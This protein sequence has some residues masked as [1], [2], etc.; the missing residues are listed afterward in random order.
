MLKGFCSERGGLSVQ[1]YPQYRLLDRSLFMKFSTCLLALALVLAAALA[2]GCS[3]PATPPATH[4]RAAYA[5]IATIRRA[6]KRAPA[7]RAKTSCFTTTGLVTT[8]I[9]ADQTRDPGPGACRDPQDGQ[10]SA[11]PGRGDP[12]SGQ[13]AM[14]TAPG[15]LFCPG[16]NKSVPESFPAPRQ[17]PAPGCPCRPVP[18]RIVPPSQHI[19]LEAEY[20]SR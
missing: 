12:Q 15:T 20:E 1:S 3:G 7:P 19:S 13:N 5:P 17:R 10:D 9:R 16:N 4:G 11:P 8:G 2:A 6:T 14:T 18:G